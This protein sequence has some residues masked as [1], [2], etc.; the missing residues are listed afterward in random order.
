VASYNEQPQILIVKIS[1]IRAILTYIGHS[2]SSDVGIEV[3]CK[4]TGILI[5]HY[6]PAIL[7]KDKIISEISWQIKNVEGRIEG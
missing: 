7:A 4:L 6:C 3:M 1:K 5:Y 2:H